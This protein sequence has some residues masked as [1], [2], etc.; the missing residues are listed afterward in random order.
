MASKSYSM[1]HKWEI[2]QTVEGDGSVCL[3][4][5]RENDGAVY[6]DLGGKQIVDGKDWEAN[7]VL[8]LS[9]ARMLAMFILSLPTDSD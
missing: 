7:I 9:E 8:S 3:E 2:R 1:I 6:F 5:W 4:V